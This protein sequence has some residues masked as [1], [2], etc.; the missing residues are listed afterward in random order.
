MPPCDRRFDVSMK[1]ALAIAAAA[2]A[3]LTG[4]P[5]H[6]VMS[7]HGLS[8]ESIVARGLSDRRLGE[9]AAFLRAI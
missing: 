5:G 6:T 8:L 3:T 4:A 2:A 9:L 1:H 7:Q